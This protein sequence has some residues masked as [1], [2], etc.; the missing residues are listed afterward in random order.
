MGTDL[1]KVV[2]VVPPGHQDMNLDIEIGK[3]IRE[4]INGLSTLYAFQEPEQVKRFLSNNNTLRGMLSIIYSKIR[5]EFPS[6]KIT[7][8]VFSDSPRSS[9]KDIVVSVATSLPVDEAIERLDKVE[10]VRWNRD[11]KDPYV[12]ICVALEYQ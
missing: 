9:E 11:S 12:N 4:A 6:E 8:E 5:K 7:L 2:G 1:G 10:D 3:T